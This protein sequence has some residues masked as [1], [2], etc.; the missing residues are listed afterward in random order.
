MLA[1]C[2]KRSMHR[3]G[4]E[5][6]PQ[7]TLSSSAGI[8]ADACS[9]DSGGPLFL[10]PVN[11]NPPILIGLVSYGPDCDATLTSGSTPV[12]FYTDLRR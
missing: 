5:Q 2:A 7:R 10:P 1:P 6:P 9:G 3:Q 8:T 11:A 4:P 12:G